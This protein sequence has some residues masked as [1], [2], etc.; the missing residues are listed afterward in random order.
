ME[1]CQ[2]K[3]VGTLRPKIALARKSFNKLSLFSSV[4][5][6]G[7]RLVYHYLKKQGTIAKCG[8]C[9]KPLAGVSQ[10]VCIA[11]NQCTGFRL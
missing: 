11:R 7:G 4:K 8:D 3:K 1:F 9:K 2:S 5:T 10:K 6:P